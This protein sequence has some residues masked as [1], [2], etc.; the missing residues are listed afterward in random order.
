MADFG[1]RDRRVRAGDAEREAVGELLRR[2]HVEGRID[3]DELQ[4]RL[5]RSLSA[6]TYAELDALVADLPVQRERSPRSRRSWPPIVVLPLLV[7]AIALSHGHLAWLVF[8]FLF[9]V[10]RP[11]LWGGRRFERQGFRRS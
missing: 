2:S 6:R 7:A 8:P 11:F 3:R 9:F 10:A 5:E 4:E 1:P